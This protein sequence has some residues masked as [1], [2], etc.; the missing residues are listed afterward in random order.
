MLLGVSQQCLSVSMR[1]R[2][3]KDL[4]A[5]VV[6]TDNKR[7]RLRAP[8]NVGY[9]LLYCDDLAKATMCCSHDRSP[10]RF[11]AIGGV[12]VLQSETKKDG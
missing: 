7:S 2:V 6:P 11:W 12:H 9:I 5:F 10:S 4:S 3:E 1:L 8:E